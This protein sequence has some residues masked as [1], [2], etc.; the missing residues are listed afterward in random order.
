MVF[1]FARLKRRSSNA[2]FRCVLGILLNRVDAPSFFYRVTDDAILSRPNTRKEN[3][4]FEKKVEIKFFEVSGIQN[5]PRKI[6][7]FK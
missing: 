5:V 3:N 2:I 4:N 7:R 1:Y 6:F